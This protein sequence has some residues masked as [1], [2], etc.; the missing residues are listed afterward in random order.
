[1][2]LMELFSQACEASIDLEL[3]TEMI[4]TLKQLVGAC[5]DKN[6]AEVRRVLAELSQFCSLTKEHHLILQHLEQKYVK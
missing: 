1:M 3:P 4:F 2:K 5:Q 6:S